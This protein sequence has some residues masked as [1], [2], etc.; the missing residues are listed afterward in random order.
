MVTW[1]DSRGSSSGTFNV[2]RQVEEEEPSKETEGP[3]SEFGVEQECD[4]LE[5][6]RLK[7]GEW[8]LKSYGSKT[9]CKM[10]QKR[11]DQCYWPVSVG[12]S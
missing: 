4:V 12:D 10:S 5:E 2:F 11:M 8:S 7:E 6:R 1:R 3:A 9:P